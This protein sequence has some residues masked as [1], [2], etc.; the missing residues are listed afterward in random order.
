MKKRDNGVD[1]QQMNALP[2]ETFLFPGGAFPECIMCIP[3]FGCRQVEE[4]QQAFGIPDFNYFR[5]DA[6][7][8]GQYRFEP[9]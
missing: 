5:E 8:T 2:S 9:A 3:V 4:L 6:L 7:Q 1:D